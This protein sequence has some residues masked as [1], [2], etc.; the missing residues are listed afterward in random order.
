MDKLKE[1]VV[2]VRLPDGDVMEVAEL[3]SSGKRRA[4]SEREF[5]ELLAHGEEET[6]V[7]AL[8]EA[9]AAGAEDAAD[10]DAEVSILW[11]AAARQR[12]RGT[13]RRLV[14]GRALQRMAAASESQDAKTTPRRSPAKK[15]TSHARG[16][17]QH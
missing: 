11:D 6:L 15:G 4:L 16:S 17:T 7:A 9:Y 1:L 13:V 5:A 12:L 14:L 2:A 3:D 10:E 8:E